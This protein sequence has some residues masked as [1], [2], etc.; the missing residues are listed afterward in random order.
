MSTAGYISVWK[1]QTIR[2]DAVFGFSSKRII[3]EK[4][5]ERY[6]DPSE[7]F[8]PSSKKKAD[9]VEKRAGRLLLGEQWTFHDD[10]T[11][12]SRR[13]ARLA[14]LGRTKIKRCRLHVSDNVA[15]TP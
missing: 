11:A 14:F 8:G 10:T 4:P 3:T 5:Y 13:N 12:A 1:I 6:C 9:A 7:I 15:R 2:S